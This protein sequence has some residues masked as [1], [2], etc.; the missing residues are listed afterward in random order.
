MT[1]SKKSACIHLLIS[2]TKNKKE[3]GERKV[4]RS[5]LTYVVYSNIVDTASEI[6]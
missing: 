5:R 3:I 1:V 4:E 6:T 2:L